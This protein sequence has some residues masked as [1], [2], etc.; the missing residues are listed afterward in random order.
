MLKL[1]NVMCG[2]TRGVSTTVTKFWISEEKK[3]KEDR[4]WIWEPRK[5]S[6]QGGAGYLYLLK[7]RVVTAKK[8]LS[9][10]EEHKSMIQ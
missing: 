4:N 1:S 6:L 9:E 2:A 5:L 7:K 8:L 3:Q 10:R